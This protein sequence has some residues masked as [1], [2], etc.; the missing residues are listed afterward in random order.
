MLPYLEV[1]RSEEQQSKA[2]LIM[3]SLMGLNKKEAKE[4]LDNLSLEY[5][6]NEVGDLQENPKVV[7][8]VPEEGINVVEG[9]KVIIYIE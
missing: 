9:T 1:Q 4:I 6:I 2:K 5:E 7:K 3:P 8:Q